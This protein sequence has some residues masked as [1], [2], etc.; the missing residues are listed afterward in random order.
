MGG[1]LNAVRAGPDS[2]HPRRPV[3]TPASSRWRFRNAV[4][5]S[6]RLVTRDMV[7]I[8]EDTVEQI[9]NSVDIVDVISEFVALNKRGKSYLGLCPF[10]DDR[11]PS[12]NVSQE[13]QIYKCFSCGAGGNAF[14]FLMDLERISFIESVR[15]LAD[16]VGIVLPESKAGNPAEKDTND[17]VYR[18]VEFAQKYFR[19]MLMRHASGEGARD[20]LI[21]RGVS[22]SAM[23]A[24]RLG[25]A[26]K[27]WDG[28]L[29]A[30]GG[31][32]FSAQMLERAG[33]VTHRGDGR[34]YD[35][36]RHR[37]I[38]PIES[39]TGRTVAYG[40]RALDPEQQPKYLNSP[41][42]PIY[43]KSATLYG[44]WKNR[45]P[46]RSTRTAVVVEGY[47]DLVA[48][49]QFDIRN[50][51]ASSGT[52]LTP[53]HA[54]LL[55]RYADLAVLV[56]D[57][58]AAG[59]A[60]TVRGIGALVESGLEIRVVTLDGDQDPDSF[61][62]QRGSDGFNE[63]T[64]TAAPIM[65]FLFD[66]VRSREDLSTS[67]GKTRAVETI[68]EFVARAK[69][70]TRRRFLTREI[71]EKLQ[72]EE[73]IAIQAVQRAARFG[74]GRRSADAAET[75]SDSSSFDPRPRMER[76]LITMMMADDRTADTVLAQI[77]GRHFSNG[78]YRRIAGMIGAARKEGRTAAAASLL[79]RCE[80]A[81]LASIV[82][83][84]SM[85][86]GI[87]NPE[88]QVPLQDYLT[89]MQLKAL[90]ARIDAL[91]SQLRKGDVGADPM[92]MMAEHKDLTRKRNALFAVRHGS[93]QTTPR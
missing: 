68:S 20:Y 47:M 61:V 35:R 15:K 34:Y 33:L 87:L 92:A 30:A 31:R 13:K 76:E 8:P 71:A 56:F 70:S 65:D 28:L 38:F 77:D 51:V 40:A 83:A 69:D 85:E 57:G 4:F 6:T 79:N 74:T 72:V 18:T 88:A 5:V 3:F 54:R 53:E 27:A 67:D 58:D 25:Y 36:F 64:E 89:R 63:L 73:A 90:D 24:F 14:R 45:E 66:W 49:A 16:Q 39:H 9:R 29:N 46:I 59:T 2:R 41:E 81:G 75:I 19:H 37:V 43:N 1:C 52:A 86:T 78:V 91:E 42:T 32:G 60:A 84:L 55:K 21:T 10:H 17:E 48:L 82:S 23:D 62:R 11:T 7:R 93:T 50:V 22:E 44:L 12:L 26:T 80:D